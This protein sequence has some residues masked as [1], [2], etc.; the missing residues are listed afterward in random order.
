MSAT[1]IPSRRDTPEQA[2]RGLTQAHFRAADAGVPTSALLERESPTD[3]GDKLDAF[4]RICQQ[5]R[6]VAAS[7]P[8]AGQYATPMDDLLTGNHLGA[9]GEKIGKATG[10]AIALVWIERR[11]RE[12]KYGRAATTRAMFTSEDD[13]IGGTIRPFL[14][15]AGALR[16]GADIAP[17]VPVSALIAQDTAIQG[18]AY[19]TIYLR[20]LSPTEIDYRR[21]PEGSEIPVSG[22]RFREQTVR[23]HKRGR[24]LDWTYEAARQMRLDKLQLFITQM[25]LAVESGKVADIV[26]VLVRGDG[27]PDTAPL[28]TTL[29]SLDASSPAS[30]TTR[31]YLGM[32]RVFPEPF[33]IDTLLA[34]P[35]DIINL[36]MLAVGPKGEL[37]ITMPADSGIGAI[38]R[39]GNDRNRD[40]IQYE[41]LDIGEIPVNTYLGFDSRF[42]VERISEIG[43]TVS[44]SDR[45]I[46]SQVEVMT[47]TETEGFASMFPQAV[48]LFTHTSA[49]ALTGTAEEDRR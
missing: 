39:I 7:N 6:V 16:P 25:A 1:I 47:F 49:G 48:R 21:I 8:A 26:D 18:G 38:R 32:R 46:T 45:F 29:G 15:S 36:E 11:W 42:A 24:A 3:K 37:L 9:D 34:R 22:L 4:G 20:D 5:A 13:A 27:N 2:L 43:A 44:E 23:M 41:A 40:A 35:A 17:K 10:R 19:R 30:L 31:S 14:T 33:R 12:A 28:T